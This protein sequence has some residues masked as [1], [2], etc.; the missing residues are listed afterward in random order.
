M[1]VKELRGRS[2]GLSHRHSVQLRASKLPRRKT[3]TMNYQLKSIAVAAL[4]M[5]LLM[6]TVT[7]YVY[8]GRHF[9]GE[10]AETQLIA[11]E[12]NAADAKVQK[13]QPSLDA[14]RVVYLESNHD[15]TTIWSAS[16]GDPATNREIL[17]ALSH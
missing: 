15:S 12:N 7:G 10:R 13:I 1:K 9:S 3:A 5:S 14:Y 16:P 4:V 2:S 8:H 6:I 11:A 17:L